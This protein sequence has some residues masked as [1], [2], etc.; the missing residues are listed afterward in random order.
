MSHVQGSVATNKQESW[1]VTASYYKDGITRECSFDRRP[2]PCI[3]HVYYIVHG[4]TIICNQSV[5]GTAGKVKITKING[6]DSDCPDK[7]SGFH[8]NAAPVQTL[9][10]NHLLLEVYSRLALQSI[11]SGSYLRR[12]ELEYPRN[13]RLWFKRLSILSSELTASA[14]TC[15]K[16]NR[17]GLQLFLNHSLLKS[18]Y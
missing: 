9:S 1:P 2:S 8:I 6:Q 10:S 4:Q 11:N 12:W 17:A 3:W 5:L 18:S 16:S 7:Q 14:L 13:D 15:I